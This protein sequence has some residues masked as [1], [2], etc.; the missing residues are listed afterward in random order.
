MQDVGSQADN[1]TD[2]AAQPLIDPSIQASAT[3][4]E[5]LKLFSNSGTDLD[6]HRPIVRL[7]SGAQ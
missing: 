2:K 6:A 3:S 7:Q 5:R 1:H 4:S